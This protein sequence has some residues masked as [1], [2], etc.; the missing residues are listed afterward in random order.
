MLDK[1][2]QVSHSNIKVNLANNLNNSKV[3]VAQNTTAILDS[4]CTS[5]Y[6]KQGA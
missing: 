3:H 1:G 4:G 5:H 6:L 2:G